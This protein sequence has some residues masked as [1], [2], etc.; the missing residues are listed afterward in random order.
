[1]SIRLAIEIPNERS[2]TM[3]GFFV[4][5]VAISRRRKREAR[6][7]PHLRLGYIGYGLVN[8]PIG[9]LRSRDGA[10]NARRRPGPDR[11]N[12]NRPRL[13]R[14]RG[15]DED[16]LNRTILQPA[17]NHHRRCRRRPASTCRHLDRN[18]S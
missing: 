7:A 8:L 13:H 11:P 12:G 18:A 3:R 10:E 4:R 5:L 16:G 6:R 15:H 1:M 17:C 9:S 2:I 14:K